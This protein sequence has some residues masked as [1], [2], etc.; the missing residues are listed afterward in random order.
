MAALIVVAIL[1]VPFA[2][3]ARYA[4]KKMMAESRNFRQ[5]RE[6]EQWVAERVSAKLDNRWTVFRNLNLPNRKG[7]L[8]LVLVGPAR[9]LCVRGK[10][11]WAYREGEPRGV[12]G[13]KG[14]YMA[15]HD[16]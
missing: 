15:E 13:A 14:P 5:G 8:D 7:D 10:G 16:G 4:Y 9:G 3:Y 2:L 1:V 6:G 11:L 12:G